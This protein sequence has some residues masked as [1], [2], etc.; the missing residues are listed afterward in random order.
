M[1]KRILLSVILALP[2]YLALDV[3]SL[4]F[5]PL[6]FLQMLAGFNFKLFED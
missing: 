2:V 5:I 6:V 1:V 3:E 4:A